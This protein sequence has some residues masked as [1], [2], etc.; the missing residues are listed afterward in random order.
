MDD[1]E[2]LNHT[3]WERLYHAVF[4]PKC[5]RRTLYVGLRWHQGE[6]FRRSSAWPQPVQVNPWSFVLA[7]RAFALFPASQMPPR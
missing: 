6:V 2:S 7:P 5:R 3:Q 4:I 1:Y